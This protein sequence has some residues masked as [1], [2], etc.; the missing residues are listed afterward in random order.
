LAFATPE[1]DVQRR[2]LLDLAS[3]IEV[4]WVFVRPILLYAQDHSAQPGTEPV[5][6]FAV[7]TAELFRDLAEVAFTWMSIADK[8]GLNP[9]NMLSELARFGTHVAVLEL[10]TRASPA[11]RLTEVVRHLAREIPSWITTVTE[12]VDLLGTLWDNPDPR[13]GEQA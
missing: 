5:L 11:D 4:A 8:A 3:S 2:T 7:E 13:D 10:A 6:R 1:S 12:T 9:D